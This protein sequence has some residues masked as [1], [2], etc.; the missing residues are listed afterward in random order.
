ML[1]AVATMF[2]L[3]FAGLVLVISGA[4][5]IHDGGEGKDCW[6]GGSKMVVLG[7]L[8]PVIVGCFH[9]A[10]DICTSIEGRQSKK[11]SSVHM[12]RYASNWC[13]WFAVHELSVL[14]LV[15]VSQCIQAGEGG[16]CWEG[17]AKS[18]VGMIV[19]GLLLPFLLTVLMIAMEISCTSREMI[20]GPMEEDDALWIYRNG[21]WVL[22]LMNGYYAI[23]I[24]IIEL[25]LL[26]LVNGSQCINY[27][28]GGAE[29]GGG[30]AGACWGGG[31]MASGACMVVGGLIFP[32]PTMYSYWGFMQELGASFESS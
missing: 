11:R 21:F 25:A 6:G 19:G 9:R 30:A 12:L 31:G 1:G 3:A 2:V 10:W 27:H 29:I 28:R 15:Q 5:C 32:A 24:G 8:L 14:L 20:L 18:G 22:S 7:L 17:T 23:F 26:L 4:R 16:V 13:V